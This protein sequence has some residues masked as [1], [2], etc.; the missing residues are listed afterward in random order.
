MI[1]AGIL[2]VGFVLIAGSFSVG[3]KLTAVATERTIGLAA[4]EE[5][6]AKIRLYG[7]DFALGSPPWPEVIGVVEHSQSIDFDLVKNTDFDAALINEYEYPS[8]HLVDRK[9]YR[10]SALCRYLGVNKLQVTVFVC[11]I[12]G[13]GVQYP[14][15]AGDGTLTGLT[16]EYPAAIRVKRLTP[17]VGTELDNIINIDITD[18]AIPVGIEVEKYVTAGSTLVDDRTGTLM[19]VTGRDGT[20]ITLLENVDETGLNPDSLGTH[21]W[22]I[23]PS[24]KTDL[25]VDGRYPCVEIYQRVITF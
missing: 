18:P 15:V 21:F 11:R 6:F 24:V 23:P 13:L 22:V 2:A 5:A 10:W 19:Y 1:S 20:Q 17:A 25:S 12:P 4:A 14:E 7:V 9:K 3:T 8:T 16:T